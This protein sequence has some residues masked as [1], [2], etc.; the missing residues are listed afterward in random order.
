MRATG[1]LDSQ[2][3][4]G[5]DPTAQILLNLL[6]HK[7]WEWIPHIVLNL[8]LEGQPVGLDQF[9]ECRFFGFVALV[10]IGL[11]I[12]NRHRQTGGLQ[13]AWPCRIAL[14]TSAVWL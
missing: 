9:V 12:G 4:V 1:A 6:D 14:P 11:G 3:S 7:V 8:L 2:K 5:Q 10:V 13:L